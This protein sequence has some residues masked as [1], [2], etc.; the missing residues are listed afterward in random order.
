MLLVDGRQCFDLDAEIDR[1]P[2]TP[3]TF[4]RLVP[5]AGG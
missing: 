3:V 1:R 5:L 4:L 2:D